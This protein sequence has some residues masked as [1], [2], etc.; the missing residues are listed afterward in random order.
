MP[1]SPLAEMS[2]LSD[3]FTSSKEEEKKKKKKTYNSKISHLQPV[4]TPKSRI[5]A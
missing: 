1:L 5:Q 3:Y 2:T 4:L